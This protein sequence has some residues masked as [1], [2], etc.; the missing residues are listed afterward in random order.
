VE[1]VTL[2]RASKGVGFGFGLGQSVD[3]KKVVSQVA[4]GGLAANKLHPGDTLLTIGGMSATSATYKECVEMIKASSVLRLEVVREMD[5]ISISFS[6]PAA[7]GGFGFGMSNTGAQ[8]VVAAVVQGGPA[9]TA[10]LISGDQSVQL[11]GLPTAKLAAPAVLDQIKGSSSLVLRV[12]RAKGVGGAEAAPAV[13]SDEKGTSHTV[14]LSRPTPQAS[15]GLSLGFTPS[16]DHL[17]NAIAEG[18]LAEAAGLAF[19]DKVITID[20]KDTS[21]L[22]HAEVVSHFKGTLQL[23]LEVFRPA[24]PVGHELKVRLMRG[25]MSQPWGISLNGNQVLTVD[26]DSPAA[27][28][29]QPGD[30]L[31][32]VGDGNVEAMS[33][34]QVEGLLRGGL[35]CNLEIFRQE[36]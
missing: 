34:S 17:L 9:A 11:N 7:G 12:A 27:N 32:S 5:L 13:P 14:T 21:V 19:G 30:F 25:V 2:E 26:G 18:G 36:H 35:S 8:H 16:G 3:G 23:T 15:F 22:P 31:L 4:D 28:K 10:G 24:A 6:R 29:L 20:G 1:Q 33:T